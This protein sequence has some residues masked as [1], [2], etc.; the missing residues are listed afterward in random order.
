MRSNKQ[1]NSDN[2]TG[3]FLPP[4]MNSYKQHLAAV[5]SFLPDRLTQRPFD[6]RFSKELKKA[7]YVD[8]TKPNPSRTDSHVNKGV[9]RLR[10]PV[11]SC[12]SKLVRQELCLFPLPVALPVG[13]VG[14][15]GH[16][17]Y[18]VKPRRA[19]GSARATYSQSNATF[20]HMHGVTRSLREN[21]APSFPSTFSFRDDIAS[22]PERLDL[23][24]H[25]LME[26]PDLK[27]G[28]KLRLLNLQH[29]LISHLHDLP[30]LTRLVFLDLYDNRV[31]DM[32]GIASLTFLR[33]LLLGKNRI[34]RICGV[35][36]LTKLDVLDLHSNQICQI[37]NLSGLLE[38][39]LLNLSGNRISRVE[40]L[41]GLNSLTELNLRHNCITTVTDVEHLPRLQRVFLSANSISRLDE[42]ACLRDC[43]SLS[44]LSI[45]G[46]PVALESC[47]RLTVLRCCSPHLQL[48][49]MKRVTEEE[50][51]TASVS[52]RKE[53]EKKKETHKQTAHKERR[54]LAIQNAAQQWE[55]LKACPELPA[56][57]GAKDDVS[58]DNSPTHSPAQTNGNAQETSPDEPRRLSPLTISTGGSETRLRSISR[59]NS[60]RDPRLQDSGVPS[61]QSLSLSDSH[62]AEL[63]GETLRL[64]G[65]GALETLE[66]CWGIQTAASVTTVVFRYIHFDSIIP[67]FLRIRLKFPNLMHLI[68]MET[69]ITHLLQLA[70]LAQIRRLDQI[71]VLPEGNPV[72]GLMLWRSF[73]IYRLQHLNLQKINGTE[74]TMNDMMASERMFGTLGHVAATETPRCRLLLLLEESR[75]RQLQFLLDGRGR[76]SGQSPEELKENGKQLGDGLSRALF[77]YPSRVN[78]ST[79]EGSSDVLDRSVMVD[80]YLKGLIQRA[81]SVSVKGDT[82]QKIWPSL[83][84]ELVRDSVLEMK[85]RQVYRETCLNRLTQR[86]MK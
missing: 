34:Q 29:N 61:V 15:L 46:N 1:Q 37:E 59:P 41:Q 18:R 10:A 71:S 78:D 9:R 8:S 21:S 35:D 81:S 60:P 83:F 54:R 65:P 23:D 62:L 84:T 36:R 33:V 31:I 80:Q 19:T 63:D 11:L 7:L 48:L 82:L 6:L 68:F 30:H 2:A 38:L 39:R 51:R 4:S 73:L 16:Q 27:G 74:V 20:T 57:N 25:G 13:M 64:F 42:L 66:R 14:D 69:N 40:N 12:E 43:R 52:A 22:S 47:Y 5:K 86:D 26:L 3:R 24:R 45:D 77:N 55:G 17:A 56:Q 72:V 53:D 67:A 32:S 44:E 85:D 70:A 75:K 76:R 49:D 50:R 58:P 28:D 79:E